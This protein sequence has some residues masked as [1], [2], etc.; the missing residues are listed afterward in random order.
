MCDVLDKVEKRGFAKGKA[1]GM[2]QMSLL[3][4][5]LFNQ[6]RIEDVKRASEDESYRSQLMKEFGID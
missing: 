5:S 4:K 3:F 2:A 1:E 6:N